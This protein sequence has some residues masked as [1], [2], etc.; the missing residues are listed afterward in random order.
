MSETKMN[1]PKLQVGAGKRMIEIPE[2]YL[3]A[4]NFRTIHDPIHARAVAISNEETVILVSLEIISLQAPEIQCIQEQIE[5]RTGVPADHIWVCATHSFS[6]PHLMPDERL[7]SEEMISLRDQYRLALQT[8]AAD[9]A[10]EAVSTQRAAAM[11]CNTGFC[12]IVANRDVELAEGWWID[13]NGFGPTDRTVSVVSFRDTEGKLIAVMSHFGM[14]SSVL[15]Q[16]E[17][18]GGGKA[19]TPD[20]AGTMCRMVEE[21]LGGETIA[22][23]LIG[24]AGDQ[25]PVEKAV[26][27]TFENGERIRTDLHEK[28][29]EICDRLAGQLAAQ[30]REAVEATKFTED[31]PQ[32][33]VGKTTLTVPSKEIERELRNLK[34]VRSYDWRPDGEREIS[35]EAIRIGTLALVGVQPELC[36]VTGLAIRKDSPFQRTLVCTMVNGAAKYMA[37]DRGYERFTYEAMNSMFGRGSAEMLADGSVQLLE[38]LVD[39]LTKNRRD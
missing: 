28:G 12:D 23:Y 20:V 34:P 15:D 3:P 7:G 2:A 19:V 32:I 13:T 24:A 18:A 35:V 5:S 10:A 26:S 11:G 27:E 25:A 4:E 36:C 8:A 33:G 30:V 16:S 21:A 38:T 6:S 22:L 17:L 37:D 39:K 1:A 14:Q 9:A 29:F 31:A